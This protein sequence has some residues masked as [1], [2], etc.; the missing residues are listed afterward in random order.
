MNFFAISKAWPLN[1]ISVS[2]PGGRWFKSNIR[3]QDKAKGSDNAPLQFLWPTT[4]MLNGAATSGL[5]P[6]FKHLPNN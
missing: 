2:Q 5:E 3:H 1:A 4:Q 6:T